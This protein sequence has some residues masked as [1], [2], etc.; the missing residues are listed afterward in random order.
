MYEIDK[1]VEFELW[2]NFIRDPL[3]RGR[4]L[5]R[6]RRVALGNLGDVASISESNGIWEMREYFGAGW[7][8]Y[9]LKHGRVVTLMLGGGCKV[10]QNADIRK[11]KK[12]L[13]AMED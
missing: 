12:M 11:V 7:R 2:L 6:L 8:M 1:T 5:A 3:T 13:L 4:L 10:T 9:Y